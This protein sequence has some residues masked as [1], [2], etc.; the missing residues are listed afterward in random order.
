MEKITQYLKDYKPLLNIMVFAIDNDRMMLKSL[1]HKFNEVGLTNY[2]T[3]FA[4]D[5]LMKGLNPDVQVCIIDYS[6]DEEMTGF[7]LMMMIK[8]EQP[9]CRFI[10][11][12]ANDDKEIQRQIGNHGGYYIPK[13]G[14]F[15]DEL[16]YAID[17]AAKEFDKQLRNSML[18]IS[19]VK[20]LMDTL[21][22]V[23]NVLGNGTNDRKVIA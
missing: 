2:K 11:L 16:I 20:T 21:K 3:F 4:I 1:E 8:A 18:L 14:D 23:S 15:L 9:Q 5:D 22:E 7:D 12:S 17:K 13:T 10:F 19:T 6:L